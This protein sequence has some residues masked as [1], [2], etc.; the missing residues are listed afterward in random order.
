[1]SAIFFAAIKSLAIK[2]DDGTDDWIQ[3]DLCSSW[4]HIDCVGITSAMYAL[5]TST[6]FHWL[7]STCEDK[8]K[9]IQK[10]KVIYKEVIEI[11]VLKDG[12]KNCVTEALDVVKK[13][14]VQFPVIPKVLPVADQPKVVSPSLNDN[15]NC[16]RITGIPENGYF[17]DSIEVENIVK[18]MCMEFEISH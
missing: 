17:Q 15:E 14:V 18:H 8:F 7:C 13:D 5:F 9:K 2:S 12:I 6:S 10:F 4:H 11:D 16:L 1:M 3:C